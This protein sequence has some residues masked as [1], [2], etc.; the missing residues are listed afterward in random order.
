MKLAAAHLWCTDIA[1]LLLKQD[2]C[3]DWGDDNRV[4]QT[5]KGLTTILVPEYIHAYMPRTSMDGMLRSSRG[6]KTFP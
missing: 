6:L 2:V 1:V 5:V 3:Q 4:G